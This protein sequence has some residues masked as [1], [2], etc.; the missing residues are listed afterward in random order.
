MKLIQNLRT[1]LY[2]VSVIT[3]NLETIRRDGFSPGFFFFFFL[4]D[5]YLFFVFPNL[6]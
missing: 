4:S 5:V 3:Q 2:A 1:P 6:G